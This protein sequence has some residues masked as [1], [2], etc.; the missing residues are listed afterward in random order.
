MAT[1][2]GSQRSSNRSS[3]VPFSMKCILE[4]AGDVVGA[5]VLNVENF[6]AVT[7]QRRV[8][9][10]EVEWAAFEVE[11]DKLV[12]QKAMEGEDRI[13]ITLATYGIPMTEIAAEIE[14]AVF[15]PVEVDSVRLWMLEGST[16][17]GRLS[18]KGFTS[19]C[20]RLKDDYEKQKK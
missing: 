7:K 4:M 16:M 12:M 20:E 15:E 11:L 8:E 13:L 6:K 19:V 17:E 1:E 2:I 9:I 10:R 14:S 3:L 5:A 18:K